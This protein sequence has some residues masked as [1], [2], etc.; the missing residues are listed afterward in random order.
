MFAE[1][2][3]NNENR[4][5]TKPFKRSYKLHLGHLRHIYVYRHPPRQTTDLV[6]G[7]TMT[8]ENISIARGRED[9]Q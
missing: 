1:I 4:H 6:I 5:K 8:E 7:V 3:A 9:N 2:P